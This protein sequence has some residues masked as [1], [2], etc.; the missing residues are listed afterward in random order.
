M[1][2]T[3][4]VIIK[5][6]E[7]RKEKDL[8]FDAI[9]AL[10]EDNGEYLSKST[11]SRVFADGS[12]EKSFRYEETLRPIAN[13]LLD[14]ENIEADDDPNTQAFKSILKLKMSVIEE[15]SAR[16]RELQRSINEMQENANAALTKEKLKYHKKLEDETRR[17]QETLD[18]AK[19]QIDLK[20]K[21]I[22]QLL[23][24]NMRLMNQLLTCPCRE[25]DAV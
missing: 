24:M 18:F 17:F 7:V 4:D 3:K 2:N 5:L 25:E 6:K 10:M 23:D 9:L 16:I 11:L 19:G 13:A 15:N 21:R 12:E 20:D 22:D 1:T 8:S 14:I